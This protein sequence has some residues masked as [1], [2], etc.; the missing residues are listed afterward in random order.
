M[1]AGKKVESWKM[2]P[3]LFACAAAL[4]NVQSCWAVM[5]HSVM[6]DTNMSA[7]K[8][9]LTFKFLQGIILTWAS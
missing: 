6:G 9:T 7:V 5:V 3:L 4:K 1:E 8:L 2:P